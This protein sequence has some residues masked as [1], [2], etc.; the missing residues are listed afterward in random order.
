[1]NEQVALYQPTEATPAPEVKNPEFDAVLVHGYWLSRSEHP[2][3]V[4]GYRGSLRT[5]LVTRAATDIYHNLGSPKLVFLGAHLIGPSFP[6]TAQLFEKEATGKYGVPAEDII[7]NETGYGTQ[8]EALEF[9]RLAQENGWENCAVLY[10][11][12]HSPSV[13][14]FTPPDPEKAGFT[15]VYLTVEQVLEKYDDPHVAYLAKRLGRSRFHLGFKGYEAAKTIINMI[16]GG[17]KRLYESGQK[18]RTEKDNSKM[19]AFITG[20]IDVFNK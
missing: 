14:R 4:D 12:D 17:T 1:M 2:D 7:T 11:N 9:R 13:K 10:F 15:P 3:N 6:S 19:N 8:S 5:R 18:T 16:P 20:L